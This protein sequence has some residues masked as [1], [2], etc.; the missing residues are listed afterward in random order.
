MEGY[1]RLD[2]SFSTHP[3]CPFLAL[4]FVLLLHEPHLELCVGVAAV[5]CRMLHIRI[6]SANTSA[7]L[8]GVYRR[9]ECELVNML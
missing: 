2:V 6:S 8:G 1:T 4:A 9:Q 5:V 3:P 7:M